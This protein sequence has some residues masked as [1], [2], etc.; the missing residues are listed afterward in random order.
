[1]LERAVLLAPLCLLAS[2][3][4]KAEPA[5]T[6][7]PSPPTADDVAQEKAPD[8]GGPRGVEARGDELAANEPV[9]AAAETEPDDDPPEPEPEPETAEPDQPKAREPLPKPLFGKAGASCQK[10][11]AVGEKVKGF[12]LPSVAGDKSISPAGYRNRVV[13]LN[14]WGTWC[15][16]CL[17]ELPEFD[18]LY[19]KYRRHGLTLVAVA[20]DEDAKPV[21]EFIDKHKLT[22]KIALDGE[23][24]AG[25]YGRPNFPF[26]FVV[27]GSGTIVAAYDYVDKKCLGELEQV[28]RN[29]L[30][31]LDP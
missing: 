30:E 24:A 15:K 22:A 10:S 14:F 6:R 23:K 27:D 20:T 18:R 12:K 19:R 31:K 7:E 9:P 11:F 25:E 17:E 21:Q 8:P 13:L 16:P 1:M 29:S 4:C 26:S 5:P 2:L 28:I 3:A